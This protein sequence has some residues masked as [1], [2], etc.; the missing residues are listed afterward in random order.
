MVWLDSQL[1]FRQ[2]VQEWCNKAQR[3]SHFI[4]SINRVQ[5]GAAPGPLIRAVN[6]C[7]VSTA[8]YGAEAWW[9][10]LTCITTVRDKRVSTGARWHLKLL[11]R[12][13]LTAVRAALPVW[14]TTPNIVLHRESGILPA[15][16]MLQQR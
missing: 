1:T 15:E 4:R 6:A 13:I 5:R 11:D 9:P 16:I 10:G 7:V 8:I 12:T 3:L 2:L 14:Q